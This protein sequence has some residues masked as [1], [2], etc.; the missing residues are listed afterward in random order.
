MSGSKTPSPTL[1]YE[2]DENPIPVPSGR[3][4]RLLDVLLD[5]EGPRGRT[6][7]FRF[8]A[9][10]LAAPAPNAFPAEIDVMALDL[11]QL[12]QTFARPLAAKLGVEPAQFVISLAD[13]D[14][15]HGEAAPDALQFFDAFILQ[16]DACV[17]DLF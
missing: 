8:L 7:R 6:L 9:P 13:R 3:A 11:H 14:V 16:D 5:E 15:P 10:D 2:G 12:C 17:Q 1:V 4:V